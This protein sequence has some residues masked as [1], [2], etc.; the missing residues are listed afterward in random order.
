MTSQEIAGQLLRAWKHDNYAFGGGVQGRAGEYA[1]ALGRSALVVAN[2]G[3]WIAPVVEAVLSALKVKGV[4]VCAGGPVGGA[5][6]NS[7]YEDV[8]AIAGNIRRHRP[9]CIVA[10]GGGS[11]I[12][13]V[14]AA[15]VLACLG[16]YSD[17][18]E[19]YFGI[20]KVA[21][22]LAKT[23][24]RLLP[25][26]AV[27][28]ASASAAHLTKYSNIT[29]M[30]RGQKKLIIDPVIAPPRA[31]FDYNVTA[32]CPPDL[33]ADGAMDGMSHC[34]EVFYG[35][36]AEK[37]DQLRE[38]AVTAI[39]MIVQFAGRALAQP[40]DRQAREALGLATDLGGYAIMVGGTNGAHLTSF[41]LVDLC[42][43]G[44][45]CG[46]MNPYYTVFFGP[47]IGR[48]LQ[49]VGEIFR[50][51]GFIKMPLAGLAGRDLALA[52]AEGMIAFARSLGCPTRL[53]ELPGFREEYITR[54]LAAAKNPQLESKLRN[55]PV[56][57][58][59]DDVDEYM[60][61][62]LEAAASGRFEMIRNMP[63]L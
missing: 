26:L 56:P 12:D 33:T 63:G 5:C 42:S 2:A 38:I 43:H 60:G 15:N 1:A 36:S 7:P 51:A 16:S 17:D 11:T 54:A 8:F 45:A 4:A 28:T 9:D 30:A 20:D 58:T 34:L 32:N 35:A 53:S 37:Y 18:L 3:T 25:V 49:S 24:G 55:M 48:Q 46:I 40:H 10:V 47:A 52:V 27:Q 31:V 62:V 29:D 14:K 23:G 13:A 59:A 57:M 6:P 41:S 19:T 21:S 22:I 61:P 44:R 50:R 39:E